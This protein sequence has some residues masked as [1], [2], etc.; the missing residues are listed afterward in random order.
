[1]AWEK[2]KRLRRNHHDSVQ[3]G[4][5]RELVVSRCHFRFGALSAAVVNPAVGEASSSV[6]QLVAH[7]RDLQ[8]GDEA[9]FEHVD[10]AL[11]EVVGAL[12][13]EGVVELQAQSFTAAGEIDR[14][15]QGRSVRPR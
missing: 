14:P 15:A 4:T 6:G 10:D 7:R 1:M 13:R 11:S 12:L 2:N 3:R 8:L 5:H 9:L